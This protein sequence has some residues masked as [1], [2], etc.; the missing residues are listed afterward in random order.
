M[1]VVP[2]PTSRVRPPARAASLCA[3]RS[4][5]TVAAAAPAMRTPSR[6]RASD[7]SVHASAK[8]AH[9]QSACAAHGAR[10]PGRQRHALFTTHMFYER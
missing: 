3:R 7:Q 5:V 2:H 4:P 1:R 8:P 6:C 10:T 9:V